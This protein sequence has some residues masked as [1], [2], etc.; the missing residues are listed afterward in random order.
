MA[1]VK[2]DTISQDVTIYNRLRAE[3]K[4]IEEQLKKVSDRIKNYAK[5]NGERDDKGSFY[6][7]ID[8]F[9]FGAVA[10][11]TVKV[12]TNA[13]VAYL[14]QR[15]FDKAIK[16]EVVYSVNEALLEQYISEGRLTEEEVQQFA[17]VNV[18]Y[19]VFVSEKEE[20]PEVKQMSIAASRKR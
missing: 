6:K 7:N 10:K 19:S 15:G 8:N 11:K 4:R 18:S 9:T 3:K 1:L 5:A 17:D 13:L 20:M 14:K 16:S 12:D 2:K